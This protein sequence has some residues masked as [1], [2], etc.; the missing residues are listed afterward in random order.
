M[1]GHILLTIHFD[2]PIPYTLYIL[3]RLSSPLADQKLRQFIYRI[4]ALATEYNLLVQ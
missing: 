1:V 3:H 2:Y 4:A